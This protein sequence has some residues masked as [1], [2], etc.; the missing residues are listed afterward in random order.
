M[1]PISALKLLNVLLRC[2]L[3]P[4]LIESLT[5]GRVFY[6]AS[7]NTNNFETNDEFLIE[8][9]KCDGDKYF[10]RWGDDMEVEKIKMGAMKEEILEQLEPL[11]TQSLKCFRYRGKNEKKQVLQ[12]MI[13][14]MN[15]KLKLS[16]ADPTECLMKFAVSTFARPEECAH[17]ELFD[18]VRAIQKLLAEAYFQLMHFLATA[19]RFQKDESYQKPMIA[20]T[21]L[22]KSIEKLSNPGIVNGKQN[23]RKNHNLHICSY[24]SC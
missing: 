4:K 13:C 12:I 2:L 23:T 8:A 19:T 5:S 18:T 20:A 9:L 7:S 16:D 22:M 17:S 24:E 6:F 21:M 3:D 11:I 10:N 14:L 15:H 1:S